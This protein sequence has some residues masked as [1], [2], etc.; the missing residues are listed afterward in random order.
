MLADHLIHLHVMQSSIMTAPA[1]HTQFGAHSFLLRM[2]RRN[3]CSQCLAVTI[4]L[5]SLISPWLQLDGSIR[6]SE[7][8]GEVTRACL[9]NDWNVL[10]F[11]HQAKNTIQL[12]GEWQGSMGATGSA[13]R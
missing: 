8:Q 1:P 6:A 2:Y 10:M 13:S 3:R 11:Q 4:S 12:M 7:T 9:P 5:K